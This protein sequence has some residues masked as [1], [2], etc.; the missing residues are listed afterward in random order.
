MLLVFKPRTEVITMT[1]SMKISCQRG[2]CRVK[3]LC[4]LI[5]YDVL[6]HSKD[7]SEP[8]EMFNAS[9][10]EKKP[11]DYINKHTVH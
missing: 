10:A 7:K 8:P 2:L 1:S 9:H 3:D 5:N 4:K 6:A 11:I